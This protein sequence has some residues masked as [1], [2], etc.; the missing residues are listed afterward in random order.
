MQI[1]K[2]EELQKIIDE[3]FEK[4][5]ALFLLIEPQYCFINISCSN[6]ITRE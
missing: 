4:S 3:A 1:K 5:T 6:E 2:I